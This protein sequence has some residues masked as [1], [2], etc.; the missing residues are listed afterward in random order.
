MTQLDTEIEHL[1][2]GGDS[3]SV[4]V[5]GAPC[6]TTERIRIL[7]ADPDPLARRALADALRE[8]SRFFVIGQASTG[9]ETFEL[10]RHYAPA[11]VLLASHMPGIDAVALC[12]RIVRANLPTRV[13]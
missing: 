3:V 7:V 4:S 12:E 5:A 1:G 11:V 8:D 2:L 9:V 13:V 6:E 10:T